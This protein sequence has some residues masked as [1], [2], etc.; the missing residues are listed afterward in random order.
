MI[1]ALRSPWRAGMEKGCTELTAHPRPHMTRLATSKVSS[2]ALIRNEDAIEIRYLV[3]KVTEAVAK[4][5]VKKLCMRNA[6]EHQH[7]HCNDGNQQEKNGEEEP[8]QLPAEAPERIGKPLLL[9]ADRLD[10]R[11][12]TF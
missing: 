1:I 2:I 7:T 9:A 8:L 3:G 6:E 4:R 11:S 5:L 10:R 12:Q